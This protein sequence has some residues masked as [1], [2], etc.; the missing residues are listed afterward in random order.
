VLGGIVRILSVLR[1]SVSAVRRLVL[2]FEGYF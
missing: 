2:R 1:F